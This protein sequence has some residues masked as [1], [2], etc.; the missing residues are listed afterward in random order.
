[1]SGELI[2]VT[3]GDSIY[4]V[5]FNSEEYTILRKISASDA[6]FEDG[7]TYT[8]NATVTM[9]SGLTA[10]ESYE[11]TIDWED[12]S[13]A[14]NASIAVNDDGLYASIIPYCT[15][16]FAEL[17]L[18]DDE[19]ED[20]TVPELIEGVVLSV[21][22]ISNDGELVEIA[23]N[24]ANDRQI[25]IVDPHPTLDWVCYRIVASN[26]RSGQIAYTDTMPI[27]VDQPGIV[28][29]WDEDWNDLTEEIDYGNDAVTL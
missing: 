20:T 18:E 8:V 1:M 19:E 11:F 5:Y 7:Q 2:T 29:T 10:S 28:I 15:A 6:T 22:R 21:Y 12:I 16:E 26:T 24:I 27:D 17:Y 9:N 23:T 4:S 25:S 3:Q 13:M 14:P